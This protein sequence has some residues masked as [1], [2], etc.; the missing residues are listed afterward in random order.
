MFFCPLASVCMDSRLYKVSNLKAWLPGG[1][2]DDG[3]PGDD[4]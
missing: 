3:E 4:G 2:H 1:D